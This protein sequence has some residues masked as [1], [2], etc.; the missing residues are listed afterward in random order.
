MRGDYTRVSGLFSQRGGATPWLCALAHISIHFTHVH[1]YNNSCSRPC[2]ENGGLVLARP[3]KAALLG[4]IAA[5]KDRFA[6]ISFSPMDPPARL[7]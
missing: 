7:D 6:E 5:W 2:I 4:R 3:H 1:R